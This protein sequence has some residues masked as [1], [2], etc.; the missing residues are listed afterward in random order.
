MIGFRIELDITS[1]NGGQATKRNPA[2]HG[3]VPTVSGVTKNSGKQPYT[4]NRRRDA[5]SAGIT[6]NPE[7]HLRLAQHSDRCGN[8][9]W[10][11]EQWGTHYCEGG[12][13][14]GCAV[15]GAALARFAKRIPPGI[16]PNM[17]RRVGMAFLELSVHP[18]LPNYRQPL[19]RNRRAALHHCESA[20]ERGNCFTGDKIALAVLQAAMVWRLAFHVVAP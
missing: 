3:Q 4:S 5:V 15:A 18:V 2:V 13:P 8:R 12:V 19:A 20:S 16:N 1:D 14:V 10:W 9:C 7:L 6:A 17:S 11:L